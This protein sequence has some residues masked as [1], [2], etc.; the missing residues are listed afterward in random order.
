VSEIV[1]FSAYCKRRPVPP[2][3]FV[4]LHNDQLA[5]RSAFGDEQVAHVL[6]NCRMLRDTARSRGWPLGFMSPLPSRHRSYRRAQAPWIEGFEPRRDDMVFERTDGS[7]Y[8][9][10]EFADAITDLGSEFALAGFSGEGA[11]LATLIDAARHGHRVSFIEDASTT[12]P[13]DG[14]NAVESHRAL[15]AIAS[16]HATIVSTAFWVKVAG[17]IHLA[18][19]LQHGV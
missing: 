12:R 5:D 11:C 17:T 16:R 1:S 14:F 7:C 15:V 19:E 3:I 4:E 10:R 18:P 13:L 8:T 2:L 9:S 6:R